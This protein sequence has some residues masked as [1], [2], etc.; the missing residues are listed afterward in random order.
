VVHSFDGPPDVLDRLLALG[1]AIGINGCS[2]KTQQNLDTLRAI[3][4]DRLLI[5]TDAPW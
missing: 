2:L 4:L 5:E 1:L 3:P